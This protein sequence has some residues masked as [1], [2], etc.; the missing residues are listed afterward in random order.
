MALSGTF[1]SYPVSSFGLYCEWSAAQ[2]ITGNYSDVTLKVYLS[3]Y[4]LEVA[5]RTDA[6]AAING[7]SETYTTAAFNDYS[8]GWKKKLLKTKTVRVNHTASGTATNIPLSASWRFGGTYSG[9]SVGTIT[10]S[11]TVDLNSIDRTAPAVTISTSGI[12]VSSVTVSASASTTCDIWQY[13]KDGGSTWTQFSTTAG[14]T[15]S[16]TISGL[17][18]NTSYTVKVRARKR[19]NQVYGTSGGST[20]KTLGNAILNSVSTVTAD[21]ATPTI[22]FNRTIYSSAFTYTLEI[23]NGSTSVLTIAIAAQ[24]PGRANST[25]KLTSAQRTALLNA[26]TSSKSFTATFVLTTKS[27]TTT[28]GNSSSKTATV[29]TTAA[30]SAPTF[31]NLSG[32]TYKDGNTSTVNV[33][34]NDQFLVQGYSTLSVTAYTATA[35]NGASISKYEATINGKTV[36]SSTTSLNLGT[37]SESGTLTLTVRAVDSRGYSVGRS[38]AITVIPYSKIDIQESETVVRRVN[39]VEALTQVEFAANISQILVS[40][41]NKNALALLRYRYKK[42]SA[43]SYGPYTTITPQASATSTKITFESDEFISLDPDYSY[44]IQFYVS[45]KITADSYVITLPQGTPLIS[46]RRKMVGINNRNPTRA[47]DVTGEIGMNGY[48]VQGFVRALE[49]S[50][51]LN[52][53]LSPGIYFAPAVSD[54][55]L[56]Y[57]VRNSV[58]VLEVLQVAS[59]FIL[60][61]FTAVSGEVYCRGKYNTTWYAWKSN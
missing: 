27:G 53:V 41:V 58:G 45:D 28:V 21:D 26:F 18:P 3:Y 61:R 29:R 9:V 60:Q 14:T 52:T 56:H 47:L 6:T 5:Q 13:S 19:S 4:T 44:N 30:N 20:I 40:N 35:N 57:P 33:T 32:F 2:S 37:I 31:S 25:L 48:N 24:S 17:S 54:A 49:T 22:T 1:Y 43:S 16:S 15:A 51:D 42:T 59:N 10:A 12:T 50:T 8:S 23:K 55:G 11:T 36:S 38:K 7:T 39:E 34:G 46:K